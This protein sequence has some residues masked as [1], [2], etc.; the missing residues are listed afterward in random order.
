MIFLYF[1]LI[2]K[3]KDFFVGLMKLINFN[4]FLI[5]GKYK[6]FFLVGEVI[7]LCLVVVF[8]DLCG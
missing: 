7:F 5:K 8:K 4:V 2:G 3:Y 1:D 6:I